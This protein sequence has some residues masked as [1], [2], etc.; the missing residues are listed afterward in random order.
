MKKLYLG[1]FLI[2]M[3]CILHASLEQSVHGADSLN[4]GSRFELHLKA[5]SELSEAVIPDT[6]TVFKVLKQEMVKSG[7]NQDYLKLDIIPL[8]VG[9]LSFP[10]LVVKAIDGT[11]Y[12][13]DRF[14]VH[15]LSV[16]AESDT[17]LRDIKPVKRYSYELDWRLYVLL[18]ILAFVLL[19]LLLIRLFKRSK[20]SSEDSIVQA[21]EVP[22]WKRALERLAELLKE[23][24]ISKGKFVEFHYRLSLI[25]RSFIEAEYGINAV[26]MTTYEIHQ[27]LKSQPLKI[28]N[29][30]DM[31]DFLRTC[32]LVKFAKHEPSSESIE[33][34][35]DWL[36]KYLM[37]TSGVNGGTNAPAI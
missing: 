1:F 10:E 8:R 28:P 30:K 37:S 4:V 22:N 2:M 23:D 36:K 9:A 14:R 7:G 33:E 13:T 20:P 3:G 11:E 34:R 31:L 17:L 32:D 29:D 35:I 6:L 25:L 15:V 27:F 16:R 21:E 18:A 5:E 24:L 12:R 19:V 26:E